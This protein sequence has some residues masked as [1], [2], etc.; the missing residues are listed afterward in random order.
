MYA[1]VDKQSFWEEKYN[2][3]EINWDLKSPNPVFA[4]LLEKMNFISSGKILIAGC[5]KG[6]DAVLAAEK[7]FEVIAV[8]FSETAI[9]FAKKFAEKK[10]VKINF[11]CEDIF[12]LSDDYLESFD[13]VYEYTTYCAINPSRR[14]EF[15]EKIS[16]LIKPEGKL[17]SV[18]FP[19]EKREGGPPFGLDLMEF[20]KN[21]SKYLNLE[22]STKIINSIPP[23]RGRE[24]LQIYFKK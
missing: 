13:V 3:G 9:N 23:R 14:E 4:D 2:K 1:P 19:V 6:Y 5:G 7:G 11:L 15:A 8:D 17:I 22:F 10:G 12:K 24:I 18:L 16:S 21:F 20:Y